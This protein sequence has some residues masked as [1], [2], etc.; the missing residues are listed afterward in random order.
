MPTETYSFL[1]STD[2]I[3]V[4]ILPVHYAHNI[5]R[6]SRVAT[7]DI[8]DHP[9]RIDIIAENG[10]IC[11]NL[12]RIGTFM[13]SLRDAASIDLFPSASTSCVRV[14]VHPLVHEVLPDRLSF[15][16]RVERE[17]QGNSQI[18]TLINWMAFLVG[19]NLGDGD[20][21]LSLVS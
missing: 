9:A 10:Q 6:M 13:R 16:A 3:A 20:F 1:Q 2:A 11:A 7:V 15:V 19:C 12:V 14:F 18:E 4:Q 5:A 21:R 8:L 17:R